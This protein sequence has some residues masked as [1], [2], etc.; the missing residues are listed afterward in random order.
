MRRQ[1]AD[2]LGFLLPNAQ[3]PLDFIGGKWRRMPAARIPQEELG[4]FTTDL[5]GTF[6]TQVNSASYR[7]MHTEFHGFDL[8]THF[9]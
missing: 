6:Q 8:S 3:K 9:I 5:S 4:G 7:Y 2:V 1:G